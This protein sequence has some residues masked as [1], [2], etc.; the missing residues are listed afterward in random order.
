MEKA[1]IT[2]FQN[3]SLEFSVTDE[4]KESFRGQGYI[5]VRKLFND[6]EMTLLRDCFNTEEFRDKMFTRSDGGSSGFQMALWWSPGDD[7]IGLVT[8]CRRIV[9]TMQQLL[10]GH[11]LYVLSSK[12]VAKEP[13]VGGAFAW[14]QDYGYFYENGVMFP[15][16]GSVSIPLHKCYKENGC[17]QIIPGSH[18]LG[19]LNHNRKGDLATIDMD[20]FS[21]I[22]D[23][24]G[25][26]VFLE[27][28]PGD[29]LFF[30]RE[31]IFRKF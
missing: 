22:I 23:R 20:R 27:S 1:N 11:E 5:M 26:P 24:L 8:R 25:E 16:C 30:H 15:D 18:L 3:N 28:E 7:T 10:G 17:L 19:R 2:T 4:M 9:S 12:L 13:H 21:A 14:H 31:F 29:V 6:K